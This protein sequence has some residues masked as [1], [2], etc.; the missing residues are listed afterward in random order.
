MGKIWFIRFENMHSQIHLAIVEPSHKVWQFGKCHLEQ[1]RMKLAQP[2][3]P[4]C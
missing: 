4:I 2:M 1:T 3:A